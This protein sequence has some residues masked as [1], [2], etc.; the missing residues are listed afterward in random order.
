MIRYIKAIFLIQTNT[1]ES[2]LGG[3]TDGVIIATSGSNE[4]EPAL[5]GNAYLNNCQARN[6]LSH[7]SVKVILV[8]ECEK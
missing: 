1:T 8:V 7:P 4:I 6:D 2:I 5:I 3:R